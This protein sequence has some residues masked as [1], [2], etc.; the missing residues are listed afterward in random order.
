MSGQAR[1]WDAQSAG[2][3]TINAQQP[4]L[5]APRLLVIDSDNLHRMIICRAA[6]KAGYV[7]AGAANFTEAAK[8]MRTTA[9]DCIMLDLSLGRRT[10]DL[11]RHLREIDCEAS[12]LIVGNDDTAGCR[13]TLRFAKSLGLHVGELV[14]KPID[15]GMLRYALEQMKIQR[16]LQR[17]L[18]AVDA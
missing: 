6:D 18:A 10:G 2:R 1:V 3:I 13:E 11:L 12:I 16:A 17:G 4:V 7:P 15:V 14:P 8:F 9:F 5:P